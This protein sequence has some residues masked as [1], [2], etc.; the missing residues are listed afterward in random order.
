MSVWTAQIFGNS[1][2]QW[3]VW[4]DINENI[5]ASPF[6]GVGGGGGGG[7]G[8]GAAGQSRGEFSLQRAARNA[9]SFLMP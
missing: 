8:G 1:T 9:D 3:L 4:A 5:K 2:V 7:G 6:R